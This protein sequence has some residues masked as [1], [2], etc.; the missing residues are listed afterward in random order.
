VLGVL[1]KQLVANPRLHQLFL[2]GEAGEAG[3]INNL[4]MV[5]QAAAVD[6]TQLPLGWETHQLLHHLRATTVVQV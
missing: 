3:I 5:A 1:Q 4:K 2:Q 6:K